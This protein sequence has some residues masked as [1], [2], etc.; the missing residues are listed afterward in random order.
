MLKAKLNTEYSE[1]V[2]CVEYFETNQQYL[3][4]T[5]ILLKDTL[6]EERRTV[7]DEGK[8]IKN[9]SFSFVEKISEDSNTTTDLA[10]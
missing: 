6:T 7:R 1:Y 3:K 2:K 4:D 8:V 10:T 5:S 9:R